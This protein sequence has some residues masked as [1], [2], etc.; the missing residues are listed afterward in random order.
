[1]S[2]R[3]PHIFEDNIEKKHCPLCDKN[4]ILTDFNK[5]SSSWDKLGRMCRQCY[6]D[7]KQN[8]RQN[9][10]KYKD[11]DKAY[12]E[13]YKNSGRRRETSQARYQE[14]KEEINKKSVGYNKK[15]YNEDPVHRI[16]CLHRRRVRKMINDLKMN[17]YVGYRK[18]KLELLGCSRE[19]LKE[20]IENQFTEGMSWEKLGI[21]G[22]HIDHIRPCASFDLTKEEDVKK[23]FHFSNLQPLWA[24]DNL[25]KGAK[26]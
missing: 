4:K 3:K 9:D 19:E 1:M 24:K 14:K 10:P 22:I 17:K 15:K 12:R 16:L 26:Y 5:Q 2:R 25:I 11:K 23:C 21:N 20:W 18:S 13:E 8:K 6:I 7:Y